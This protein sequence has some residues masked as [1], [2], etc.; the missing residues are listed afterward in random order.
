MSMGKEVSIKIFK[1][2]FSSDLI[3]VKKS[4]SEKYQ[5]K[6]PYKNL[7]IYFCDYV[8]RNSIIP[9][10]FIINKINWYIEEHNGNKYLIILQAKTH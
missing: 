4:S 9:L 8:A 2:C 6:K 7:L 10:K 3:N 1:H 5:D